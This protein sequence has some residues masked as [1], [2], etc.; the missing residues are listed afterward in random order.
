MSIISRKI[1]NYLK[2]FPLATK[3][4]IASNC[5]IPLKV[6]QWAIV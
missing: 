3:E 6:V 1:H 2:Q 5:D 4:E